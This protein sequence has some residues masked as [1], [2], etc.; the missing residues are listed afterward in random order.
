MTN[1]FLCNGQVSSL[2]FRAYSK[3]DLKDDERMIPEGMSDKDRVCSRCFDH[4][5]DIR[6]ISDSE[7]P[8]NIE[9]SQQNVEES[10]YV[11][12]PTSSG[13]WIL[14]ILLGFVGGL[15]MYF[16]IMN[17]DKPKAQ[18][19]LVLGIVLTI[20]PAIIYFVFFAAAIAL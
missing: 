19:G 18:N 16:I 13:I 1:C 3:D 17:D 8:Q 12:K 2:P 20:I 15:I 9:K 5:K 7:Y 4:N 10:H 14:P 11:K 6:K